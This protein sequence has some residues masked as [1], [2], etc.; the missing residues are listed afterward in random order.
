MP[1]QPRQQRSQ[2]TRASNSY[3]RAMYIQRRMQLWCHILCTNIEALKRLTDDM[4]SIVPPMPYCKS[5]MGQK[6]QIK[7]IDRW[8]VMSKIEFVLLQSIPGKN[9][10]QYRNEVVELAQCMERLFYR[11][12]AFNGFNINSTSYRIGISFGKI[13]QYLRSLSK[14]VM[15]E[16]S[17]KARFREMYHLDS[18]IEGSLQQNSAKVA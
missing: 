14:K 5:V 2:Q 18:R 9:D 1:L 12:I 6:G 7:P 13:Y 8:D 10:Y 3:N 11:S 15:D 4:C 17:V 16:Q